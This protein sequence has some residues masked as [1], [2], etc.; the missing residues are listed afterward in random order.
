MSISIKMKLALIVGKMRLIAYLRMLPL[1]S[2]SGVSLAYVYCA[3]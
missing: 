1:L 2:L 3:P